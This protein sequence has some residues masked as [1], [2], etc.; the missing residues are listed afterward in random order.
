MAHLPQHHRYNVQLQSVKELL[1]Y[2]P[3]AN[4]VLNG[5]K[6]LVRLGYEGSTVTTFWHRWV[7]AI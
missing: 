7:F 5:E 4:G 2:V 6:E 3:A 1:G